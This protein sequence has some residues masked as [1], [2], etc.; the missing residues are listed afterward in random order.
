MLED[1]TSRAFVL[2][3]R[4]HRSRLEFEA[5]RSLLDPR[6]FF[7][8]G[9][10]VSGGGDAWSDGWIQPPSPSQLR[11]LETS[12]QAKVS[13]ME[14]GIYSALMGGDVE[15]IVSEVEV[16]EEEVRIGQRFDEIFEEELEQQ[17]RLAGEEVKGE[18]RETTTIQPTP[19]IEIEAVPMATSAPPK[20]E[21]DEKE[22]LGIPTSK[23]PTPTRPSFKEL[24]SLS[25]GLRR[26]YGKA[27]SPLSLQVFK[28]CNQLCKMM[29]VPTF[30][31][32]DGTR[33]GGGRIHE[34]EAF[35]SVLVREGFADMVVSEDSDVLCYD[36]MLLRGV[37]GASGVSGSGGGKRMEIV[38]GKRVRECLF[39]PW[40]SKGIRSGEKGKEEDQATKM[41]R[42]GIQSERE[43]VEEEEAQKASQAKM[44]DFAL[45]CGTDFCR[46]I[47][48][49]GPRT[50]LKLIQE[51][52]SISKILRLT[53]T[54]IVEEEVEEEAREGKPTSR[55]RR[56]TKVGS[57]VGLTR[58][59]SEIA[60]EVNEDEGKKKERRRRKSISNVQP[61]FQPPQGM[62]IRQYEMEVTKA[63][64]VYN[65]PP[66][67]GT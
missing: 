25:K 47:P 55:K 18:E 14:A 27:S 21:A 39:P 48:G 64:K 22:R 6:S 56:S 44:I 51:H 19:P 59:P 62:T 12:S 41:K 31:T 63:R 60:N 13:E 11:T 20:V 7:Q 26:T 10:G 9:G 67:H 16:E 32:G 65:E 1:S 2:A 36:V 29:S 34:A 8:V 35:A 15:G 50:A 45:L 4:I 42:Q 23:A 49:V 3:L 37:L 52:G 17:G 30:W 28:E 53:K 5:F 61:R 38:D 40:T 57:G 66:K 43:R 46:T 33:S 24:E 54:T 58:S